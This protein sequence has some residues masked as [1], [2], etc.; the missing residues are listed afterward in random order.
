VHLRVLLPTEVLVDEDVAKIIAEAGNGF[1]CLL[2]L[3]V[4]FVAALVP[5]ILSYTTA[6]NEERFVAVDEG[7]LV[8][9]GADVLVSVL[10]ATTGND[11]EALE[12]TVTESF[13]HID[14]EERRARTALARLEAGTMRRFLEMEKRVRG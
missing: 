3:H 12:A 7:T 11:L 8:K 6:D 13:R 5:G 9:C 1:F 10:N 14:T 4:D 2:P